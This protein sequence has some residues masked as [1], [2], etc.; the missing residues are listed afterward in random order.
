[1]TYTRWGRFAVLALLATCAVG[2][3]AAAAEVDR[4]QDVIYGR[5]HGVVLTLDVLTPKPANGIGV[6]WVV[7]GGWFSS[8]ASIRPAVVENSSIAAI[9]FS[10][11]SMA[12]S[13]ST[14]FPKSSKICTGRSDSSGTMPRNTASIPRKLASSEP[15]PAGTFP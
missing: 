8:H 3:R 10:P 6:V 1:M 13:R 14:P 5:K 15:P 9:P 7:S 12:A 2:G 11:S 4:R